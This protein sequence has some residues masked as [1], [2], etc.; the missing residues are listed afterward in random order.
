MMDIGVNA[1]QCVVDAMFTSQQEEMVEHASK[2]E[3][4]SGPSEVFYL[5]QMRDQLL[6]LAKIYLQDN[7]WH[8]Q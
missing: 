3:L 5:S 7:V 1:I 2:I 6:N 4:D 8:H